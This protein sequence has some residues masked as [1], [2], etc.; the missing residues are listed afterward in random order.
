MDSPMSS[1]FL[2]IYSCV[3]WDSISIGSGRTIPPSLNS[4]ALTLL[5]YLLHSVTLQTNLCSDEICMSVKRCP[6]FLTRLSAN[7][8]GGQTVSLLGAS[9][10]WLVYPLLESVTEKFFPTSCVILSTGAPI[11]YCH[12]HTRILVRAPLGTAHRTSATITFTQHHSYII[13]NKNDFFPMYC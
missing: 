8:V 3:V 6:N 11:L 5:S 2:E 9:L 12:T 13:Y 4:P 1:V 10:L 7:L